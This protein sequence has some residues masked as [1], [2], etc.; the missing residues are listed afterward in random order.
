[1]CFMQLGSKG[2]LRHE[3][4]LRSWL[5][6]VQLQRRLLTEL[7]AMI[8][9]R[10][11]TQKTVPVVEPTSALGNSDVPKTVYNIV[12]VFVSLGL[13]SKP[14]ALQQG[15]WLSLM[16]L[17]VLTAVSCLTGQLIVSSF[18]LMPGPRTYPSLGYYA[19]GNFGKWL[20]S[21][22]VAAEFFGAALVTLIFYWK[23]MQLFF[24]DVAE[25]TVILASTA[26][27]IPSVWLLDF[28]S[29]WFVGMLGVMACSLIVV[30]TMVTLAQLWWVTPLPASTLVKGALATS[31]SPMNLAFIGEGFSIS[32]GIYILSLAGHAALP[33]IHAA[34]AEPHKYDHALRVAFVIMFALY[35]L[36]AVSGYLAFGWLLGAKVDVLVSTNMLGWKDAGF[37]STLMTA[38]VVGKSYCSISPLMAIISELPE[39]LLGWQDKKVSHTRRQVLRTILLIVSS[40]IAYPCAVYNLLP[41]VEALTGSMC[42]MFASVVLP[43][44]FWVILQHRADPRAR[45][46]VGLIAT[47]GFIAGVALTWGD[48]VVMHNCYINHHDQMWAHY[49][50][51]AMESG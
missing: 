31:Q 10:A 29:L 51:G 11:S 27:A 23:N 50:S 47:M 37:L 38:G 8:D 25:M 26:V 9:V 14:Y 45:F 5:Q 3:Q 40:V 2:A 33:G 1:M 13:L 48:F 18:M 21:I 12:N 4:Q 32:I 44:T 35:S 15:G 43:S 42:S 7:G 30:T 49:A 22:I 20:V 41:M 17:V 36:E 39:A 16:V 34:M 6:Q 28:G 19:A 24:P 46:F